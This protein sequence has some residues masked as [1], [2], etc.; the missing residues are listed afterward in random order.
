MNDRAIVL[1]ITHPLMTAFSAIAILM[2][3]TLA[4]LRHRQLSAAGA[5]VPERTTYAEECAVRPWGRRG[6]L[7]GR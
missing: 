1:L 7:R 5:V 2:G 3:K 6:G 4:L